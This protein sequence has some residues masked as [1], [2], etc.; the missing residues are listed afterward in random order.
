MVEDANERLAAIFHVGKQPLLRFPELTEPAHLFRRKTFHHPFHVRLVP[1][2]T[3]VIFRNLPLRDLLQQRS[4]LC[5]F[6]HSGEPALHV[7]FLLGEGGEIQLDRFLGGEFSGLDH[8]AQPVAQRFLGVGLSL[9]LGDGFRFRPRCGSH[10]GS[11]RRSTFLETVEKAHSPEEEL[12]AGQGGGGM[13]IVVELVGGEHLELFP[14]FDH[15]GGSL[16]PDEVDPPVRTDGRGVDVAEIGHPG[17]PNHF[18]A[19][20]GPEARQDPLVRLG[21]IELTVIENR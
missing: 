9:A 5:L 8:P 15:H 2:S 11:V 18:A 21:E 3:R 20:L 12:L 10:L 13:K 4:G 6:P 16:S 17:A 7:F 14:G 19:V 1:V